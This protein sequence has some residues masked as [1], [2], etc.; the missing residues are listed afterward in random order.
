MTYEI[1]YT[2]STSIIT[3]ICGSQYAQALQ[4]D[5]TI[6]ILALSARGVQ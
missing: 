3:T 2:T 6:A 4:A 1:T 5:P